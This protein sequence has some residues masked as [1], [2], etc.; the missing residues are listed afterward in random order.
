MTNIDPY[1][2]LG[3]LVYDARF[4]SSIAR[5][6]STTTPSSRI[7]R[8]TADPLITH[9]VNHHNGGSQPLEDRLTEAKTAKE[10]NRVQCHT[11]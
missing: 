3:I 8:V 6:V 1:T 5:S 2:I 11:H 7:W 4:P 9:V 10:R